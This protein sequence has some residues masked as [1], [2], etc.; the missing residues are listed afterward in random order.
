MPD[1]EA[2]V[3][4]SGKMHRILVKTGGEIVLL[5]HLHDAKEREALARLGGTPCRCLLVKQQLIAV[6]RQQLRPARRAPVLP[7]K[8]KEVAEERLAARRQQYILGHGRP[9]R[10]HRMTVKDRFDAKQHAIMC[11]Q[12]RDIDRA[13]RDAL[14][15][16]PY[17][18]GQSAWVDCASTVSV[19][20]RLPASG[21][22]DCTVSGVSVKVWHKKHTWAAQ[23]LDLRLVVALVPGLEAL[24]LCRCA[25]YDP[26]TEK[27]YPVV[28]AEC[29]PGQKPGTRVVTTGKQGAGLNVQNTKALA[30]ID[31]GGGPCTLIKWL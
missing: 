10:P 24:E 2:K 1:V 20:V 31:P 11:D 7:D 26:K 21:I 6:L 5:D 8:L 17:R 12:A 29:R 9:Y 15:T 27:T 25:M 18:E 4:C 22:L 14:E 19:D 23:K 16:L 28:K 13:L 3:R 30:R